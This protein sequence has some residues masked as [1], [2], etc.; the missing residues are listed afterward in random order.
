MMNRTQNET[1]HSE[2]TRHTYTAGGIVLSPSRHV[3]VVSQHGDS[4]SLPKGHIDDR[5]TPIQAALREIEEESGIPKE[6]L[7]LV[8]ELGTYER[9]RIGKGGIGDD[10]SEQK[11]ITMFLF[12]TD[13]EALSPQDPAN[14]EARWVTSDGVAQLLTHPKDADFFLSALGQTAASSAETSSKLLF[15]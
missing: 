3:L 15:L 4:W 12:E 6:S 13:H 10:R 9:F 5:E 11:T 14:P 8:R 1:V 2:T 7:R